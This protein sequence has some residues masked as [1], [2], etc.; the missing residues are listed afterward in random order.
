M[1]TAKK[2]VYG[3]VTVKAK[4]DVPYLKSLD[5]DDKGQFTGGK[6][7]GVK[8]TFLAKGDKTRMEVKKAALFHNNGYIAI[9]NE[10]GDEVG[11]EKV[12]KG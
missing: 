12:L 2:K 4:K 8:K 5:V 10:Q 11:L 7:E 3:S 9:I 1:I 6:V